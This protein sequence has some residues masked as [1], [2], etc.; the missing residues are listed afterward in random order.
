MAAL[1]SFA[2]DLLE[3]AKRFLEKASEISEME[4]RSALVSS[5]NST[6][7]NNTAYLLR[8]RDD[9]RLPGLAWIMRSWFM[10]G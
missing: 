8:C 1:S 7:Y 9:V 3:E 2:S 6:T 4:L 5:E 10:L